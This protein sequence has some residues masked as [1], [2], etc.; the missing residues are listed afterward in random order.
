[1]KHILP[2]NLNLRNCVCGGY[3]S[4]YEGCTNKDG[5]GERMGWLAGS[6]GEWV[7]VGGAVGVRVG[8]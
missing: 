1:M 5:V 3:T 7:V 6:V 4:C 2:E 8:G